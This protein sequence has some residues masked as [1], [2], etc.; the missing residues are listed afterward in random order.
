MR[1]NSY[2][3][4]GLLSF[5]VALF[6]F[7]QA[8]HSAPYGKFHPNNSGGAQTSTVTILNPALFHRL[9]T[10]LEPFLIQGE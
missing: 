1:A 9:N 3:I 6:F 5:S 7:G 2:W 4:L 10:V 8:G